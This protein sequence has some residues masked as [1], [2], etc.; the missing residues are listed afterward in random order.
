MVE[1]TLVLLKPD[2][3]AAKHCGDVLKRFEQAGLETVGCK[4]VALSDALLAEHY[5]HIADKPFYPA[6]REFMQSSPVIALALT[7]EGAILRVRELIGPTDSRK[8]AKGTIRGDY[9]MDSMLNMVHASDSLQTAA[10]ELKRF[11]TELELF[12]PALKR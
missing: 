3:I 12:E 10:I 4:M 7:G 8:A 11:F 1:T 5:A 9:G 2:C 6:L